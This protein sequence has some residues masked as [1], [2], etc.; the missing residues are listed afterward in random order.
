LSYTSLA[1][2]P[3]P[4]ASTTCPTFCPSRCFHRDI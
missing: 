3:S 2:N 1:N 4:T